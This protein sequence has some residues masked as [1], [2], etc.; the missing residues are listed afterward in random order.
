SILTRNTCATNKQVI[1]QKE[2]HNQLA[3]SSINRII[4]LDVFRSLKTLLKTSR[5][6]IDNNV[7]RLHYSITVILLLAFCVIITTKQY[8]GD[9]ID[10]V[11]SEA[12]P[13]RFIRH[14]LF[15]KEVGVDVVAPGVDM[16]SNQKEFRYHKYYQWVCFV[17]FFQS[18]LFYIPRWLWKMWEGGKIQAL[19]MDLDVGVCSDQEKK[20]KKKLLVDYLYNSRG[21]HD[22]YAARYLFCEVLALANVIAQMYMLDKFFDGEFLT[23]GL[24]V[25]Q[26]AQQDQDLTM[27]EEV[28][29]DPGWDA[30][31]IP[32][33]YS[34]LH[35]VVFYFMFGFKLDPCLKPISD[36]N[37]GHIFY[38]RIYNNTQ[39][40]CHK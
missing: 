32:V 38:K 19:M 20:Q 5:V 1:G 2:V 12:I 35:V 40:L 33:H 3:Y 36:L 11:R 16:E 14:I 29:C 10:C 6:Q 23:Y 31:V 7:F 4:M 37:S 8:V 26:F 39:Y 28:E 13:Q 15:H 17:L 25:I 24:Q 18:T 34:V 22:W 27:N 9:P 21:H 30:M